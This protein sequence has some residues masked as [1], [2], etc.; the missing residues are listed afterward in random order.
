MTT[1]CEIAQFR[2]SNFEGNHATLRTSTEKKT[3]VYDD[4]EQKRALMDHE[5]HSSRNSSLNKS[6]DDDS[7]QKTSNKQSK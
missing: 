5:K 6:I 1:L 3:I 7:A 4:L 2:K